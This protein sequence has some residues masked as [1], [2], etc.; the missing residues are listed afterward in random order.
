M[1]C[2]LLVVVGVCDYFLVVAQPG[3]RNMPSTMYAACF[4]CYAVRCA[5]AIALVQC[6]ASVQVAAMTTSLSPCLI[7]EAQRSRSCRECSSS[8][9]I[10]VLSRSAFIALASTCKREASKKARL[11][12]HSASSCARSSSASSHVLS[13]R[14][15]S[16]PFSQQFLLQ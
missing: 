4:D 9:C 3:C 2:K 14:S 13:Q 15:L 7:A 12:L 6:L 1:F 8:N 11:S 16:R 10:L 5:M